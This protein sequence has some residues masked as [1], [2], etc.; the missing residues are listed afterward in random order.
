MADANLLQILSELN[1]G[2]RK[3]IGIQDILIFGNMKCAIETPSFLQNLETDGGF[4]ALLEVYA[5]KCLKE[6]YFGQSGIYD[7]N[8]IYFA[9]G[10]CVVY[11]NRKDLLGKDVKV[12]GNGNYGCTIKKQWG[13]KARD[14][15]ICA[16]A[17]RRDNVTGKYVVK[18]NTIKPI[19]EADLK[20]TV[21]EG[22]LAQG[23]K[24]S[25]SIEGIAE[26]YGVKNYKELETVEDVSVNYKKT[27]ERIDI[28][29]IDLNLVYHLNPPEES[30]NL[31]AF[32][33]ELGEVQ[34]NKDAF[35]ARIKRTLLEGLL[36]ENRADYMGETYEEVAHDIFRRFV[37]YI[38]E[39][40]DKRLDKGETIKGKFFVDTLLDTL[41]SVRWNTGS[42]PN[43]ERVAVRKKT[44]FDAIDE[45]KKCIPHD[46]ELLYGL[47]PSS[48]NPDLGNMCERIPLLEDE[49]IMASSIIAVITGVGVE[50]IVRNYNYC[51]RFNGLDKKTWF[52][53]L[54]RNPYI[55]GMMGSSL[56]LADIDKIYFGIS[57]RYKNDD[58]SNPYTDKV[59]NEYR[60]TLQFLETLKR[61]ASKNILVRK[62]ALIRGDASE[63]Y[64]NGKSARLFE[65]NGLPMTKDY[66][67]G[68]RKMYP[69]ERIT[70]EERII[71]PLVKTNPFTAKKI[72]E[73]AAEG[74][75]DTI[76][77]T[78]YNKK[79]EYVVLTS[80]MQ[81]EVK[82]YQ[83]LHEMGTQMTGIT[84]EQVNEVIEQF[85]EMKGFKLE[86]LQRD[87][88]KLSMYRAGVLSGCAGSGKTTTS[89]CIVKVIQD[90]LEGYD[91]VFSTPTGKACRRLAEVVGKPVRT[92]H[93]QFGVGLD[94]EAFISKV[95]DKRIESKIAYFLD[96]MA[97]CNTDL[98]YDVV[99]HLGENDLIYFLG[100]IKQLP[101]IGKGVPFAALMDILPCVELGVS[102]RAAAGSL[103][104]YN[105]TLINFLSDTEVVEL[106]YDNQY[107][108]KEDCNDASIPIK[109]VNMWNN[110]M[111]GV[112]ADGKKYAED[113]I[114]VITGYQSEEKGWSAPNLNVPLQNFL[115]KKD[116]KLFTHTNRQFFKNDRV[117]HV[118]TN[119]YELCRYDE[120]APGVYQELVTFGM[121]NGE[122]GKLVGI[123]RSDGVT[124]ES[125][126]YDK[127]ENG[128]YGDY[129][130]D[131]AEARLERQDDL[132]DES[133]L[134]DK[135]TYFIKVQVYDL[136]LQR[137]VYVLYRAHDIG[138]DMVSMDGARA[139]EGGDMRNVELAYALT[140]HK[141]Q[142]SQNK[143]IIAP[144]GEKGSP[145]FINRNMINV[146]VTRS[147]EFVGMIGSVYGLD[148]AISQGRRC[149]SPTS[150]DDVFSLLLEG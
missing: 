86:S 129:D 125:F 35:A 96:E 55:L 110:L 100:D 23:F 101:P 76:E 33:Q 30:A 140:A 102:K 117:I 2:S 121:M 9:K 91:L 118:N 120:V 60:S 46:P 92:I 147:E 131:L 40:Y 43:D 130:A 67:I 143:A 66:I 5:F 97:M 17:F 16:L 1:Y 27:D 72:D 61:N 19:E 89:D 32:L 56:H 94:G 78:R 108:V 105:T 113:D 70:L 123:L 133:I 24:Y 14:E 31:N 146:I 13:A 144:F 53:S 42:K 63:P 104:N 34:A 64:Y 139:F 145:S 51:Y 74:M 80:D 62:S 29:K 52:Y 87:G 82:I 149:K 138:D 54:I 47:K 39:N 99:R 111:S 49:I 116:N 26:F 68:I 4:Y 37:G 11:S 77:M 83:K 25:D 22:R 114:Q 21:L 48:L 3:N 18:P 85:E 65:M 36:A 128:E 59:V 69:D 15:G 142:G 126:D 20:S 122:Q 132:R 71:Y 58:D 115:R 12:F 148:S 135:R 75:I 45:M 150:A 137:D 98:L 141:M 79:D 57:R 73:V 38:A 119:S 107:F 88:I 109:V 93:S 84:E 124:I 103:V 44:I 41:Y 134:N 95:F 106:M 50:S 112:Y 127:Y 7:I 6:D 28:S 8:R 90:K 81:K 10:T 136:S